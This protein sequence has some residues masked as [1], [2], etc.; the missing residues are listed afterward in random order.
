M[1][2]PVTR[3]ALLARGGALAAAVLATPRLAFA[4]PGAATT[5]KV[6][7]LTPCGLGQTS[8]CSCRACI[9]HDANS[10]FPSEKAADG[11]RAH[12]GCDCSILEGT[13]HNGTYVALFGNSDHLRNYRADLRSPRVQ[14][15]L[16][17]HP[18]Q[19]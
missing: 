16:K 9:A 4:A 2:G 14:E 15:L 1:R 3:R 8:P 17:N 13:L 10:L 18:A 5:A 12:I 6:Y 7:K 11:N 19:F